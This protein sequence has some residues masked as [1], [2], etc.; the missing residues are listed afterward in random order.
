MKSINQ[1]VKL[2]RASGMSYGQWVA[3]N[4]EPVKPKKKKS[5]E[6]T[7]HGK[8]KKVQCKCRGCGKEFMSVTAYARYC[9]LS[10]QR[11]SWKGSR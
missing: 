9:S 7:D 11:N 1:V 5:V 8:V 10:C 6:L 4:E 2:A 3:L